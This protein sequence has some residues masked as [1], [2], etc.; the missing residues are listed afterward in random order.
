MLPGTTLLWEWRRNSDWGRC[1]SVLT[2]VFS[3]TEREYGSFMTADQLSKLCHDIL[4]DLAQSI[5]VRAN[6]CLSKSEHQ[7]H[8]S[9]PCHLSKTNVNWGRCCLLK[10]PTSFWHGLCTRWWFILFW[11]VLVE[12]LRQQEESWSPR[13]LKPE[14]LTNSR[15]LLSVKWRCNAVFWR[16]I[17]KLSPLPRNSKFRN[18]LANF[19]IC[20]EKCRTGL[21]AGLWVKT[22]GS[23]KDMR[24]FQLIATS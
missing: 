17:W 3:V 16:E 13:R 19:T 8:V 10:L 20:L 1:V 7:I 18:S 12:R 9:S 5:S 24:I 6:H 21:L 2:L 14:I 4:V 22:W 23:L 15:I 11:L